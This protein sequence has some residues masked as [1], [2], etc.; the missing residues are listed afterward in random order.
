MKKI[1]YFGITAATLLALSPVVLT[2]ENDVE[3]ATSNISTNQSVGLLD[4]FRATREN[5]ATMFINNLKDFNKSSNPSAWPDGFNKI[6]TAYGKHLSSNDFK[7]LDLESLGNN[8]LA[9]DAI[10]GYLKIIP[11]RYAVI[12]T[13]S[14]TNT[15]DKEFTDLRY[16]GGKGV[17]VRLSIY[18]PWNNLLAA[19]TLT[20]TNNAPYTPE[21]A[22]KNISG[23]TNTDVKT[24]PDAIHQLT[25][26]YGKKLYTKDFDAI[27]M[28]SLNAKKDDLYAI[29]YYLNSH[30][31]SYVM[32]GS[33]DDQSTINDQVSDMHYEGYGKSVQIPIALYSDKGDKVASNTITIT[34][35]AAYTSD[36]TQ[37][38]LTYLDPIQVPK[39][40]ATVTVKSADAAGV[41]AT[42]QNGASVDFSAKP[43]ELYG[44]MNGALKHSGM[45]F[46]KD[47]FDESYQTYYQPVTLSFGQN[48]KVKVQAMMNSKKD[49]IT[50]NGISIKNFLGKFV[51]N[52][53]DNTVTFVRQVE[54]QKPDKDAA[55]KA[56]NGWTEVQE[57]GVVEVGNDPAQ[58]YVDDGSV[59]NR[60]LSP[61]TPWKTDKYRLNQ[62]TNEIQYH[63]STHEWVNG[64]DVK[65]L[66]QEGNQATPAPLTG[67]TNFTGKE[68]VLLAGS[69]KNI[70]KLFKSDGTQ[71]NR[72]IS[73]NTAWFTD[74]SAKDVNGNT[75]Y[76]VSTDEWIEQGTGVQL[77]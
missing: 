48:S 74:K 50:V 37:L 16:N 21:V 32:V 52:E 60:S 53:S 29:D 31:G 25:S 30:D 64:T 39:D 35:K 8:V 24:W 22:F 59:S 6:A 1:T 49:A 45:T 7:N 55:A 38:N 26:S 13:D 15:L 71:S 11:G 62:K 9:V 2:P 41:T 14:G 72:S 4:V 66:Q 68:D 73:G 51:S 65:F 23:F 18:N 34:N 5:N 44:T 54:V 75:Y 28:K 36:V 56:Y 3:A 10:V 47:T 76:R 63:V 70:Y 46:N 67:I 19:K 27:D 77:K 42:D 61:Y 33:G 40:T 57:S 58:L 17:K 12:D 43:G 69:S 20:F